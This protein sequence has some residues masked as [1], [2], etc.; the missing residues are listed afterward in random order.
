MFTPPPANT[1]DTAKGMSDSMI[2]AGLR[3]KLDDRDN[4]TPGW[5]Y[6]H[7][8]LKGVPLRCEFGPRDMEAGHCVVVRRD[9]GAKETVK[10]SDLTARAKEMCEEMQADMLQR[11]TE[12]RNASVVTCTS[13]DGFV[14]ALDDCKMILTPWCETK[15]SEELVKKKSQEG[16]E[17]G[18]AKTLCIPFI[19]PPLEP[20][21]KCFITGA[22]ATTWVIWGRSY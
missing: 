17:G 7:W 13:W 21:T 3:S 12:K 19:Q 4:Y 1:T 15:E 6:N 10:L 5:K 9:T 20:G 22:P 16:S 18:A 8:E 14:E 2:D 11:A